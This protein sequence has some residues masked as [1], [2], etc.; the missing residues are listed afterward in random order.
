VP[1]E[2][3][4]PT[5]HDRT[6]RHFGAG[7]FCVWCIWVGLWPVQLSADPALVAP[8]KSEGQASTP[9]ATGANT[10]ADDRHLGDIG[11]RVAHVNRLHLLSAPTTRSARIELAGLDLMPPI[12]SVEHLGNHPCAQLR[13]RAL[14][15]DHFKDSLG[16]ASGPWH[17]ARSG[18]VVV[19]RS[20]DSRRGRQA[21]GEPELQGECLLTRH[22]CP[23]RT[24]RM[25]RWRQ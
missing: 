16:E 3:V 8:L 9:I 21:V 20:C 24:A 11:R 4:Q 18:G 6:A 2:L 25:W 23:A 7:Q 12:E 1:A 13:R 15:S 14:G 10:A 5:E 22:L 17:H 19:D